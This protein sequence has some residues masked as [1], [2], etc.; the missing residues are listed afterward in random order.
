MQRIALFPGTFDPITLGHVDV[1]RRAISLFDKIVI[2]V[3]VNASKQ[4][5]YSLEQRMEWI[6][7]IF[8]ADSAITVAS[9]SG[10]TIDFCRTIEANYILRG[11]RSVGDFE[12]EKAIADMN[13]MLA[14]EMET[15]FLTCSPLYSTVSSTMVRDVIRHGGEAALFVPK[16]V[17]A[18]LSIN[19]G[20]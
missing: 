12:Y 11:I 16:E 5:M 7:K 14:P 19:Q 9:Y 10:L 15:I 3:G 4:T 18:K 1:I 17:K 8:A 6:D 20:K 13:R 2:G